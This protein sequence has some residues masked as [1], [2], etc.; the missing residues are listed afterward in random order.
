[1]TEELKK[2]SLRETF[3]DNAKKTLN[4]KFWKDRRTYNDLSEATGIPEGSLRMLF[5]NRPK[6]SI[7]KI[8]TVT[9]GLDKITKDKVSLA[10][11]LSSENIDEKEHPEFSKEPEEVTEDF[12]RNIRNAIQISDSTSPSEAKRRMT[13]FIVST[14]MS[15]TNYKLNNQTG[16][17]SLDT[18]ENFARRLEVEPYE[19]LAKSKGK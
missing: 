5:M 7:E 19:L 11:L 2:E 3:W 14:G 17:V 18:L 13:K 10:T 9:N 1:M 12:W 4:G 16:T 8:V 6:S 15:S